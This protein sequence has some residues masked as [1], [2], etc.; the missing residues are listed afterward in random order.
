MFSIMVGEVV[1]YKFRMMIDPS[2]E[3]KYLSSHTYKDIVLT[4]GICKR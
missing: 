4:F 2:L 1:L 3:L